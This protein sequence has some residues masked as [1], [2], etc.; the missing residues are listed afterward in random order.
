MDIYTVAHEV[1]CQGW[2]KSI[3]PNMQ[4]LSREQNKS[5]HKNDIV[6]HSSD[7]NI[8]L[9]CWIKTSDGWVAKFLWDN[10][11]AKAQLAKSSTKEDINALHAEFGYPSAAITHATG[12]AT[13]LYLTGMFKTCEDCALGKAKKTCPSKRAIKLSKIIGEGRFFNINSPLTPTLWGKKHWLS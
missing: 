4:T 12:R 7:G 1:L 9:D 3:F 8:I 6:I 13:T 10:G 11:H 2:C 5:D